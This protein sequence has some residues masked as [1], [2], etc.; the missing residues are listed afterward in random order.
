LCGLH[1]V[2]LVHRQH[3]MDIATMVVFR[4]LDLCRRIVLADDR[5]PSPERLLRMPRVASMCPFGG[6]SS[7]LHDDCIAKA[8][9]FVRVDVDQIARRLYCGSMDVPST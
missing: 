4:D 8:R 1:A 5:R 7:A 2:N 9:R 3:F 6:L